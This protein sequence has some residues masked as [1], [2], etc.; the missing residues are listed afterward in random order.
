MTYVMA[1]N[2]PK[3]KYRDGSSNAICFNYSHPQQP[4]PGLG[5]NYL[6]FTAKKKLLKQFPTLLSSIVKMIH[7]TLMSLPKVENITTADSQSDK[8]VYIISDDEE[9]DNDTSLL[10]SSSSESN[11]SQC[12]SPTIPIYL[13]FSNLLPD[14]KKMNLVHYTVFKGRPL[15]QGCEGYGIFELN[16]LARVRRDGVPGASF[17]QCNN[18]FAAYKVKGEGA[19]RVANVTETSKVKTI[20]ELSIEL[21]GRNHWNR[22]IIGTVRSLEPSDHWTQQSIP[23]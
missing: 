22:Q 16:I 7:F 17:I 9:Q 6:Q 12:G 15:Y 13:L 1:G 21:Q 14:P 18:T 10:A 11:I 20:K 4:H 19:M 5:K 23:C 2:I 3:F 8:V